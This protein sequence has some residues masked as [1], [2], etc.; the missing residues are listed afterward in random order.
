LEEA[1][2]NPSASG[3]ARASSLRP[4]GIRESEGSSREGKRRVKSNPNADQVLTA[5]ILSRQYF[6]PKYFILK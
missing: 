6:K 5:T 4:P 1:S 3:Y 2:P